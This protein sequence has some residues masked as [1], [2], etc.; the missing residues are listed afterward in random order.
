M[1]GP[2]KPP[3]HEGA[4]APS[5]TAAAF[6]CKRLAEICR[7]YPSLTAAVLILGPAGSLKG[8]GGGV[9]GTVG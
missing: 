4:E 3:R 6:F 8:P 5:A 7:E 9:D 1:N 2:P